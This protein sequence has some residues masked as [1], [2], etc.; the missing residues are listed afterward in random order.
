MTELRQ[1][2]KAL[3]RENVQR[4]KFVPQLALRRIMTAEAV[5]SELAAAGV[6][7]HHQEEIAEKVV[8]SGVN[9][10]AILILIGQAIDILKFIGNDE[11]RD[12]RLPF[13]I[14]ALTDEILLPNADD[15]EEKQ[16]EFMVPVFHRG[17]LNRSFKDKIILPF[18]SKAAEGQGAF[19]SV[20]RLQLDENHQQLDANFPREVG[21]SH[22]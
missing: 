12:E 19:G 8:Q 20:Y 21:K 18:T 15:F 10:F 14:R 6:A 17:T 13:D 11:L 22:A 5:R 4:R 1:R 7:L 2:I 9:I 16:W 3:R